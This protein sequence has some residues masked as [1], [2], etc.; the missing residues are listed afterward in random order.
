M[1]S[2]RDP[3]WY[4][5]I[6]RTLPKWFDPK[7]HSANMTVPI[8]GLCGCSGRLDQPVPGWDARLK[9]FCICPNGR[10]LK[11]QVRKAELKRL[12]AEEEADD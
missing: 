9:G 8:C 4:E 2:K 11:R 7:V 10:A 1:A 6:V 5:F 3:L 12:K